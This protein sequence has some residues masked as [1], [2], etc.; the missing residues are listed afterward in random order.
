MDRLQRGVF[1]GP[2]GRFV[3]RTELSGAQA[4]FLKAVEVAPPPRFQMIEP[5]AAEETGAAS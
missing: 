4:Q 3:Q 2:A 1:E 5:A